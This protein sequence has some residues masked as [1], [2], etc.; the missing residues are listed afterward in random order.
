[1]H[2]TDHGELDASVGGEAYLADAVSKQLAHVARDIR[3]I[4]IPAAGH[5]IA[6][7]NPTALARAYLDF[8]A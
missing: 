3:G 2:L 4:V 8:F 6:W 1:M 5:N 7:E